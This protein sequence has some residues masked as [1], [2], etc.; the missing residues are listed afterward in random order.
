MEDISEGSVAS[1]LNSIS[2]P[3]LLC[4]SVMIK[5]SV[6]KPVSCP[7]SPPFCFPEGEEKEGG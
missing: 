3:V 5:G 1:R 4:V 6:M 7:V 2:S